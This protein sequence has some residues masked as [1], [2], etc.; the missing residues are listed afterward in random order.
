VRAVLRRPPEL[1]DDGLPL[2]A[3]L[4]KPLEK[5]ER[6]AV[7]LFRELDETHRP[8]AVDGRRVQRPSSV[9]GRLTRGTVA[10]TR[11]ARKAVCGG[12]GARAIHPAGLRS[13]R[14]AV[15]EIPRS[16]A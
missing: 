15:Y 11:A 8:L 9:G 12:G 10:L 3:L 2:T 4:M 13:T 7:R 5:G 14:R 16:F 1:K 6:L